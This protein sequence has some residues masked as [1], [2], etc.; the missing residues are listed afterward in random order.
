[1]NFQ[2]SIFEIEDFSYFFVGPQARDPAK[3]ARLA[4]KL[5]AFATRL[6][7]AS[8]IRDAMRRYVDISADEDLISPGLFRPKAD[9]FWITIGPKE[10]RSRCHVTLRISEAGMALEVFAPHKNFTSALVDKIEAK[11]EEFLRSINTIGMDDPYHFR[12]RE[13]HYYDPSSSFK[14]QR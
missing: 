7:D 9:N 6:C 11:P 1:M 14:G 10:R 13:A 2:D 12:H 8:Q 3:R 5:V 4:E